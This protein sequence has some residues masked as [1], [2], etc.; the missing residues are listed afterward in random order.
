VAS[1]YA[2]SDTTTPLIA[3]LTAVAVNIALKL[4]LT[5]PYGVVGLALGT[6]LGAWVNLG[7]LVLLAYRRDWTAPS[8][9]LGRIAL[10]VAAASVLLWLFAVFGQAPVGRFTAGLPV[11]RSETLVGLMGLAGALVYAAALLVGLR[12]LKVRL[13]RR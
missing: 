8:R 1:F 6:A 7:L 9:T 5:G 10:A 12:L 13:S 4:V 3:S 11:W 2:R